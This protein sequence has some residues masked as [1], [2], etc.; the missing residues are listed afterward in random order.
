MGHQKAAIEIMTQI[1]E[2]E[3][4][5]ETAVGRSC[6]NWYSRY[7]TYVAIMG[8]FPT[9]LPREWF[10]SMTEYSQAQVAS[11]PDSLRWK[12]DHRSARL[13]SISYDMSNDMSMLYARGS[14]GQ[15]SMPDFAREHERVTRELQAWRESWDPA[16]MDPDYLVTD[17]CYRKTPD[18]GDIVDPCQ[19]GILFKP[20]LFTT[21]LIVAEWHSIMI[22][23]LT[24]AAH[25]PQSQL[26]LKLGEHAYAAC[27]YFVSVELWPSK[28]NGSMI[29]LQG[30][31]S[32]AAL[33]LP[34]DG[35]HKMWIRRKLAC[36]D[37]LG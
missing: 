33:F 27:Q 25:V 11:C 34:R 17:F 13:R 15:M 1:F 37:I 10:D 22:M 7:D 30:C 16:L 18:P 35:K 20:P 8:G 28:P 12:I 29:S 21:T 31:I 36:L 4:V 5:M 23:H 26:I 14:R 2:P 6:L 9:E 19:P 3:T 24:Q 32:I